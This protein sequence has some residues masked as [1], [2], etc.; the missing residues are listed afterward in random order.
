M[1]WTTLLPLVSSTAL[2]V[3]SFLYLVLH[4]ISLRYERRQVYTDCGI[5]LV[6]VNPFQDLPR[7]YTQDVMREYSGSD[8]SKLD[9]HI[10]AVAEEAYRC[11]V[12]KKQ[13]QTIIVSGES[14]AGKTVNAKF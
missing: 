9:P 4:N 1:G 6:A 7:L 14:G 12:M 8:R 3:L 13:N 11:M 5:I 2:L 10:F